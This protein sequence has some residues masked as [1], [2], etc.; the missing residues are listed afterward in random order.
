MCICLKPDFLNH[1]TPET[2]GN[3]IFFAFPSLE[4]HSGLRET[5]TD[6]KCFINYRP[7]ACHKTHDVTS[8]LWKR[9]LSGDPTIHLLP[10]AMTHIKIYASRR[11]YPR[12][13]N[14]YISLAR[15]LIIKKSECM[16]IHCDELWEADGYERSNQLRCLR[17]FTI[18][19]WRG[20]YTRV[21]SQVIPESW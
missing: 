6:Q 20:S 14:H 11:W 18:S 19:L 7:G 16:T 17:A 2:I 9:Q 5:R 4:L 10:L 12:R 8:G 21:S 3:E 15:H 1:I 13:R